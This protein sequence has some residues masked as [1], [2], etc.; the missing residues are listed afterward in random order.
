MLMKSGLLLLSALLASALFAGAAGSAPTQTP[1]TDEMA[2]ARPGSWANRSGADDLAMADPS[3]SRAEHPL[4]L[5][6]ADQVVALL[7]ASIPR[8]NGVEA[9]PYRSI[10]G[11][12]YTKNGALKY[13]V[14][15]PFFGYYCV[16]DTP[17]FPQVRGQIR[18]SDE[19][20]TWIDVRVNDFFWLTNERAIVAEGLRAKGGGVLFFFPKQAGEWNGMPLLLPTIH[21][22]QR[23]E[24]VIVVPPAR[25]P[26]RFITREEFLQ[27]RQRRV[28]E[29]IVKLPQFRDRARV[30]ATL[31]D[32]LEKIRGALATLSPDERQAEAIVRNP[33]VVPGD[34]EKVFATE[35]EGGRRV[36]VISARFFDA[37]LP[38]HA[39]QFITVYWRWDSGPK[40]A[41]KAEVVRQFKENFD[42]Q[43]LRSMLG[44]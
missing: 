44:R 23:S 18:L 27:A 25:A 8:L 31:E 2:W 11:P 20:G 24:A 42:V 43:A 19:T 15:V 37:R 14:T 6:K 3:Y 28:Q 35:A 30:L 17:S 22:A 21:T 16:P 38:R 29:K 32:E 4:A 34:R 33:F 7:K 1:C 41:V 9:R 12:S 39:V 10:R 5:R 36:F 40:N 26:Y 13:G